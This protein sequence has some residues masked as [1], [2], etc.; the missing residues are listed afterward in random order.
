MK[1]FINSLIYLSN[2]VNAHASQYAVSIGQ[3][4][5]IVKIFSAAVSI[6]S[7]M[8]PGSRPRRVHRQISGGKRILPG[9]LPGGIGILSLQGFRQIHRPVSIG[10]IPVMQRFD[11]FQ[12]GFQGR[13]LCFARIVFLKSPN[14]IPSTSRY[15]KSNALNAWFRVGADTFF[16]HSQIGEKPFNMPGRCRLR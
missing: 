8:P 13:V 16:F 9:P 4:R 5:P 3:I 11:I 1:E 14:S 12:M 2:S 6:I 15:R 10:K 7:K